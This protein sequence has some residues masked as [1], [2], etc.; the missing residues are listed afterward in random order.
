MAVLTV[1]HTASAGLTPTFGVAAVAGDAYPNTGKETA[2]VRNQGVT[3]ISVYVAAQ[4][5]C[6]Q[7]SLH[8]Y[9]F[10]VPAGGQPMLLGPFQIGFYNDGSGRVQMTYSSTVQA[11]PGALTAALLATSQGLGVGLYRYRITLVNGSGETTGGTTATITTT[12]GFQGVSLSGIPL[13]PGGT[14]QRKVYRTAVGGT[15]GTEKLLATIADNTTTVLTDTI[16]DT[17]LG[18]TVPGSNTAGVPAPG[19]A[20]AASGAAGTPNGT[21]RCQVTFVNAA[22]ETTGGVEFTVTVTSQHIAWSSIPLGPTGTTA[23]KLYRTIAGGAT[24]AEKLLTTLADN[25][26]TTFDDNV[27][28]GSLTTAIPTSN[29]ANTVQVA[30]A[31]A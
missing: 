29:T 2:L 14:T 19:A 23:R 13:G 21:Y 12:A 28:D 5:A 7:G 22:G 18:A 20:A 26:T 3:P 25:T 30:V 8:P 27:A 4:I 10:V 6:S 11:A 16:P 1:Q 24:G 9:G 15:A 31:A 17:L